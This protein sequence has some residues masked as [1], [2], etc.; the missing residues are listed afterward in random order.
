MSIDPRRSG[1]ALWALWVVAGALGGALATAL[2]VGGLA[3]IVVGGTEPGALPYELRVLA[4][5]GASAALGAVFQSCLLAFIAPGK[6]AS[7]LWLLASFIGGSLL[8][9]LL[10]DIVFD[11]SLTGSFAAIPPGSR[12]ALLTGGYGVTFPL[13]LGLV[14][15]LVLVFV[16]ARKWALPIWILGQLLPIPL[17]SFAHTGARFYAVSE[18]SAVIGANLVAS[19][20]MSEAVGAA[21][22]G[23]ALVV[24]F[25]LHR[26]DRGPDMPM[27]AVALQGQ[28]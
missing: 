24:I 17:D 18:L 26:R 8:F 2:A 27:P 3:A 5:F 19:N 1:L 14:Q 16:T 23:V 20:A 22:T 4:Y 25:R 21:V 13:A 11:V 15:G 9:H 6:W 7:I 12:E 28:G 10:Q